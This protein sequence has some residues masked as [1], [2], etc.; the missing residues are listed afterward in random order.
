MA[1]ARRNQRR[2]MDAG[3]GFRARRAG[4]SAFFL[5]WALRDMT[6]GEYPTVHTRCGRSDTVSRSAAVEE[7]HAEVGPQAELVDQAVEIGG[8]EAE[9]GRG[10]GHVAFRFGHGGADQPFLRLVQGLVIA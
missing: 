2:P 1:A 10:A 4:G 3:A 8:L 7:I 5:R 9:E 6:G